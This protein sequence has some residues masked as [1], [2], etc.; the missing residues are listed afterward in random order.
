MADLSRADRIVGLSGDGMLV[1]PPDAFHCKLCGTAVPGA[2]RLRGE[3]P[4]LNVPVMEAHLHRQHR[5]DWQ[6]LTANVQSSAPLP[7]FLAEAF[8]PRVLNPEDH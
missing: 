6:R 8:E 7:A 5:E 4:Q 3:P 2:F 1:P